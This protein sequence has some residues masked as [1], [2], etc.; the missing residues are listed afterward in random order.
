MNNRQAAKITALLSRLSRDDDLQGE[1][2]SITNQK[3]L[4]EDYATKHGFTNLVHYSE[5]C[6]ILEPTRRIQ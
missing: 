1:S 4:L 3:A 2:N 5:A 6:V